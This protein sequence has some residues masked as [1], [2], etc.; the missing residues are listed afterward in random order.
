M[1]LTQNLTIEDFARHV[2]IHYRE[3]SSII[4]SE[5]NT[6]FF[7]FVNEYRVNRAKQLLL[8]PAFA[9]MTILDILLESGFNSKSS[10]HRFFKRYT[11]MSAAEFRKQGAL[12][13]SP[14]PAPE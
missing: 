3:V 11:G 10:F 1:Y 12:P 14:P 9:R 6:N 13:D 5:F 4:N 2:G 7:E 8:D